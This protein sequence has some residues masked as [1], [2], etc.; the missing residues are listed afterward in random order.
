MTKSQDKKKG[1]NGKE[2]ARESDR[3]NEE[4]PSFWVPGKIPDNQKA[5]VKTIG[6]HPICPAAAA[7][8]LHDFSLKSLVT[9]NFTVDKPSHDPKAPTRTCPSCNKAL[10]NSTKAVLGKPCGH[11]LCKPCSDKFQILV[12]KSP[13][14]EDGD[15]TIRCYICSEDVTPGRKRKKKSKKAGDDGKPK[16]ESI[17]LGLVE[18]STEGTGFAGGGNNMVKRAGVAFQ[19]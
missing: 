11:V 14:A 17:E 5:D 1:R 10:S 16:E 19:C 8:K 13:G 15:D 2:S 7:D 4:L 12:L 3:P 6:H 18:L 9:V